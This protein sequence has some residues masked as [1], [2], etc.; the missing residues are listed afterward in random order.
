[1]HRWT[2][3]L[4]LFAILLAAS[5]GVAH[6]GSRHSCR[7]CPPSAAAGDHGCAHHGCSHG[8]SPAAWV[9]DLEGVVAEV[10]TPPGVSPASAIVEITLLSGRSRI[11][12]RLA[13]A[14]FLQARGAS[15]REGDTVRVTGCWV[16][17]PEGGTLA[18]AAL[19]L[20]GV[21][22]ALPDPG[23]CRAP[24]EHGCCR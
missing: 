6:H 4:A 3:P 7:N 13:P 23:G 10:R 20:N 21:T 5:T 22:V 14:G 9:R 12:V 2:V 24:H 11:P 17:A 15:P 19:T 1:M 8:C 16:S 18:A